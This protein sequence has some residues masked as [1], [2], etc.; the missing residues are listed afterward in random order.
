MNDSGVLSFKTPEEMHNYMEN[1]GLGFEYGCV[2]ESNPVSCHSWAVWCS[3]YKKLVTK[4]IDILKE[5][6]FKRNYGDSCYR[7]GSLK[8]IGGTGVLRDPLE[9]FRS[10][11][12]GCKAG[13]QGKCCQAAGRLL[14]T[15]YLVTHLIYLLQCSYFEL[16][17]HDNVPEELFHL[18]WC[19]NGV[20]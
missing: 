18:G 5:N 2:R 9:A 7:F 16:G 17:C 19:T 20:S 15:V 11:E 12:H 8:I 6:C 1:L 14:L 10:F 13:K 4:S 3:D